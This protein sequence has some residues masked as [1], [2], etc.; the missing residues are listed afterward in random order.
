MYICCRKTKYMNATA[1]L[2][3]TISLDPYV[4]EFLEY[5]QSNKEKIK[6]EIIK[7]IQDEIGNHELEERYQ[8]GRFH[9]SFQVEPTNVEVFR[10]ECSIEIKCDVTIH[11]W[12]TNED[13]GIDSS[14]TSR[15]CEIFDVKVYYDII[16]SCES[17]EK[18][19]KEICEDAA[20]SIRE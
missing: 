1:T 15:E 18:I 12:N 9:D 16:D 6:G 14:E 8:I 13:W 7:S 11:Y 5:L 3:T 20:K 10:N 17:A 4:K 2:L 19:I